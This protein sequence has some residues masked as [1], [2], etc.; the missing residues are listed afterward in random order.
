MIA[1]K[2]G[3]VLD[4]PLEPLARRIPLTPNTLSVIGFLITLFGSYVLTYNLKIGGILIV[5]GGCFDMLDGIVARITNSSSTFGAFLDSVLDRYADAVILLAIAWNL[6]KN[7]NH[8]GVLLCL[9]T[10]IGSFLIS[11][12]RARAEGLGME[13]KHG[14]ME[15]PER[16]I[17]I[18]IGTITGIIMPILW[19]LL[20][21]THMTVLQR[22][23]FVWKHASKDSPR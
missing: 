3:H 19:I 14:L 11:Y 8:A 17:L 13:C 7:D 22:V 20:V 4:K 21:L 1:E 23:H 6:G 15:R 10:L 9:G 16:I 5:F 12:A 2:L 18:A